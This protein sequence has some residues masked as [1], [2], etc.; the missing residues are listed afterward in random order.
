MD[1][2][3]LSSYQ[4]LI[5]N[6]FIELIS[7]MCSV[8]GWFVINELKGMWKEAVVKLPLAL[9]HHTKS[10]LNTVSRIFNTCLEEHWL[11]TLSE[12]RPP[13]CRGFTMTLS[14]VTPH[15]VALLW[16]SDRPVAGIFV[17]DNTQYSRQTSPVGFQPAVPASEWPQTH[18]SERAEA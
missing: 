17:P 10:F 16:T 14:Y 6:S 11:D 1:W 9:P 2:I 3:Y 8:V 5:T 18:A 12:P 13:H 7:C 4:L 15:S